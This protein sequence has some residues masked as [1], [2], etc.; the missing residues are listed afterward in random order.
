MCSESVVEVT[1][2]IWGDVCDLG[3]VHEQPCGSRVGPVSQLTSRGDSTDMPVLSSIT[4]NNEH[5]F[6]CYY[7]LNQLRTDIFRI[8]KKTEV[9]NKVCILFLQLLSQIRQTH[10][11]I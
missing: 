11:F 8:Y 6:C 10:Y 3:P 1:Y 4:E 9:S 7:I 2:T 5:T